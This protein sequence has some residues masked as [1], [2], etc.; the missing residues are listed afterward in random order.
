MHFYDSV[1]VIEKRPMQPPSHERR[2]QALFADY[3]P[4][5]QTNLQRLKRQLKLGEP[6]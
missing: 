3:V 1:L 2:G 5:K 4:R 6:R